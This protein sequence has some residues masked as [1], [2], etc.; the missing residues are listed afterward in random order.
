MYQYALNDAK[1]VLYLYYIFQGL[2]L[3][4]NKIEFF[5]KGKY[6]DFYH[7][8]KLQFFKDRQSLSLADNEYP[9][10]YYRNIL[11]KI[12]LLCLEMISNKLKTKNNKINIELEKDNE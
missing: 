1:S 2:Y 12:R 6:N 11:S 4:L 8:L 3:Y 7:E 5:E 9:E 10:G